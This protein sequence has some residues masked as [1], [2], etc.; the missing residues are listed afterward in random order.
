MIS[1]T[2][3]PTLND[4]VRQT[5]IIDLAPIADIVLVVEFGN[6]TNADH[7]T[8]R[9]IEVDSLRDFRQTPDR[10]SAPRFA[11]LIDDGETDVA[12][13]PRCDRRFEVSKHAIGARAGYFASATV[14]R[15]IVD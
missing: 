5:R 14:A 13:I 1:T 10:N 12:L 6:V 15:T 9:A 4:A 7:V 8:R 3:Q 2:L 11:A